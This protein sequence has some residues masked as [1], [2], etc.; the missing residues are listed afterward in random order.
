MQ[1][2]RTVTR[3]RATGRRGLAPVATLRVLF[4]SDRIVEGDVR[5]VEPGDTALGRGAFPDDAAMS[6]AHAVITRKGAQVSV[7]DARSH[8]GTFHNGE[9]IEAGVLADGDVLRLGDTLL[10]FCLEPAE[11]DAWPLPGLRGDSPAIRCAREALSRAAGSDAVLVL[12]G[13]TGTGKGAAACAVH[14]TSG[15]R[16]SFVQVNAAAVPESVAES[17]FFGHRAG[18]FTGAR[19]DAPGYFRAA[20]GGT[21]FIDEIGDL[22]AAL[23]PKL[24]HAIEEGAVTPLGATTPI[25]TDVRIVTATNVDLVQAVR[26][27]RFR[28]DLYAR[29]AGTTVALPPLR[30]RR[31]DILP[32][33]A[34]HLAGLA[35][36]SVDLAERLVLHDWRFNVRELLRVAEDLAVARP[37]EGRLPVEAVEDRLS[38]FA[39]REEGG[40]EPS[41]APAGSPSRQALEALLEAHHGV[42]SNI[43]RATGRSTKQVYRWLARHGLDP[44]AYR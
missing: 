11:L 26:T 40:E 29:I 3:G 5:V 2:P 17:A 30:H 23:Q 13:E 1:D 27:G 34:E 44:E 35:P 10:H 38:Q 24:L 8:N 22:P 20:D 36:L 33:L 32:L 12:L 14:A 15:R 18:A 31:E 19:A 21:L 7:R 37:V 6:R 16:G 9:P 43:A 41:P 25:R 39:D 4:S 28:A 42:V